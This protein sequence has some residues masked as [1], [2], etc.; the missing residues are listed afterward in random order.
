MAKARPRSV[1]RRL[2]SLGRAT[3]VVSA[4]AAKPMAARKKKIEQAQ[5]PQA[6]PKTS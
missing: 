6:R 5:G 2:Q 1:G 3:Q 4:A